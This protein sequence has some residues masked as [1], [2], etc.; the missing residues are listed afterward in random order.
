VFKAELLDKLSKIFL[1]T[2]T[3]YNAPSDSHE[4]DVLFVDIEKATSRISQGKAIS[5]VE[6][7]LTVYSNKLQFGYFNRKIEQ[8]ES[9]LTKQFFFF[10]IDLNPATSPA[11][12]QN[13]SE[14][15]TRFIYLYSGQYDPSQ[16]E[17]TSVEFLET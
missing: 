12:V 8:A 6:G 13:I 14:R 9:E 1:M 10:D 3:T 11:R 5:K 15:R 2:K 16:G 17:L 4:Q 7:S